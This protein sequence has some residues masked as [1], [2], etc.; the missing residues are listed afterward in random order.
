MKETLTAP[1]DTATLTI[2]DVVY[3]GKGLARMDGQV[4][5]VGGVL[6]GETVEVRFVRRHK[7]YS[8]AV[9]LDITD[10]SPKRIAPV[11]PLTTVCPGCCY[12]HADYGTEIVLKQAQLVNLLQRQVK[13]DPAICLP[14][15]ASP[16]SLEYRNRISL[17]ASEDGSSKALGY[18]GEDNRTVIDVPA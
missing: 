16:R 17:H 2:A 13:V 18:I 6:P 14:P 10:P 9:L 12:Q 15:V 4:V 8:E 1:G 3:R 5:F 7:N 11:C